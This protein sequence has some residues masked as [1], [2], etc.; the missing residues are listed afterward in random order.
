MPNTLVV[1]STDI[2]M[3][4]T[5]EEKTNIPNSL[6]IFSFNANRLVVFVSL[7]SKTRTYCVHSLKKS[8]KMCRNIAAHEK[9]VTGGG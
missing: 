5:T 2:Y 4:K 3:S 7:L 6:S 8:A 1:I 9:N